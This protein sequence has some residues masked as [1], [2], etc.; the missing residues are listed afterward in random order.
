ML[1]ALHR[2]TIRFYLTRFRLSRSL[3]ACF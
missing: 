1:P 2:K 3:F